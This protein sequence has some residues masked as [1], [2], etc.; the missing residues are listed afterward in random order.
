M[1]RKSRNSLLAN[2]RNIDAKMLLTL[3]L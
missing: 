1:M 3:S 2:K